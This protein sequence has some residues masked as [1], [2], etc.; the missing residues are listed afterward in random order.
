MWVLLTLVKKIEASLVSL[1]A[2]KLET[3][4]EEEFN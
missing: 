3:V 2:K 4:M 1:I